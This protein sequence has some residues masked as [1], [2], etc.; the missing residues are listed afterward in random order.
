MN[1][2][3]SCTSLSVYVGASPAGKN[4]QP[5]QNLY[6]DDEGF[7]CQRFRADLLKDPQ[8]FQARIV[9]PE[10]PPVDLKWLATGET[11]GVAFWQR[12]GRTG[13]ATI[14]VNG[15]ECD[16]EVRATLFAFA[17]YGLNVPAHVWERLAEQPKP[18]A[19]HV[20]FDLYHFTDPVIATTAPALGNAFFQM[21]G[22]NEVPPG[23]ELTNRGK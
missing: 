12:N 10:L 17:G 7:F 23:E 20:F 1:S 14:L 2:H 9:I 16:D 4:A 11:A 8:R 6:L 21:F 15:T 18:F 3:D 19:L 5:A 13:A 22:S